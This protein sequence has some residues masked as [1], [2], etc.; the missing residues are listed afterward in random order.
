MQKKDEN[1]N[2]A[3]YAKISKN[4]K[5]DIERMPSTQRLKECKDCKE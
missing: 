5:T 2:K 3:N 4:V 1:A